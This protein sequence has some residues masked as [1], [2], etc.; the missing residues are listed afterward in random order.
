MTSPSEQRLVSLRAANY[1][2]DREWVPGPDRLDLDWRINEMIGEIGE[3]ANALKKVDR[4]RRGLKGSRIE[5]SDVLDEIADVV[6]CLDLLF[7]TAGIRLPAPTNVG[8][9]HGLLRYGPVLMRHV[10]E[11][12][13]YLQKDRLPMAMEV[14]TRLLGDLVILTDFHFKGN[15]PERVADKFNRTSL[16][17]GFEIFL[18]TPRNLGDLLVAYHP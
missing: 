5:I 9:A 15:L 7:M 1:F 16:K 18:K 10:V 8:E 17:H 12:D 4:E 11:L 14:G 13:I 6:I 3:L 2:R